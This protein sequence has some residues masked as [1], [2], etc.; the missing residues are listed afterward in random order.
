MMSSMP[1]A[2]LEFLNMRNEAHGDVVL[3]W[4]TWRI[5]MGPAESP[6]VFEGRYSDV[7][8]MHDGKWVYVMDHASVPLPPP[9]APAA[10]GSGS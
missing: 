9:P 6:Q 1:G 4:G 5:T 3:G 8:A 7:K 2:K 10:T